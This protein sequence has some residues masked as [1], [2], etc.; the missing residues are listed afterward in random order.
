VRADERA[1]DERDTMDHRFT[2]RHRRALAVTAALLTGLTACTV[3]TTPA[4]VAST[5]APTT[6]TTT[7]GST[8]S[9]AKGPGS[10]IALDDEGADDPTT[11]DTTDTDSDGE[12]ST[13]DAEAVITAFFTAYYTDDTKTMVESSTAWANELARARV[14]AIE[15]SGTT[16]PETNPPKVE[17]DG[18]T[19]DGT[20]WSVDGTVEATV[21]VDDGFG[22]VKSHHV[23]FSDLV[24]AKSEK[25]GVVLADFTTTADDKYGPLQ[26]R[27]SDQFAYQ[28]KNTVTA[29]D[30]VVTLDT[31]F[32]S[33][34][35]GSTYV[36]LDLIFE[37]KGTTAY[38][39]GPG[40]LGISYRV[41][42]DE[43]SAPT[44]A[45]Q[46]PEIAPGKTTHGA[47]F[48]NQPSTLKDGKPSGPGTL[49]FS[50]V[51]AAGEKHSV[52]LPTPP[53]PVKFKL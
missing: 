5:G 29:G 39:F 41:D 42:D 40:G 2:R 52:K 27:L 45:V 51:D 11:E 18:V 20:T 34:G 53:F 8:G 49:S 32:R 44:D 47:L 19:K 6:T 7:A 38:R 35:Y 48:L 9:T 24:L 15:T 31:T 33:A 16:P 25:K 26:G 13:S 46:V 10:T 14:W 23:T 22:G 30:V 21:D 12:V 28:S 4:E 17:I 50:I 36:Q 1:G 43:G 37:N 3:T